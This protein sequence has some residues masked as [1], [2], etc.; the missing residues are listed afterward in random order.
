[1]AEEKK[2]A[3]EPVKLT[4]EQE[5]AIIKQELAGLKNIVLGHH[6]SPTGQIATVIHQRQQ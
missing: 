6:H 2:S 5:I 1:M 4:N 3:P